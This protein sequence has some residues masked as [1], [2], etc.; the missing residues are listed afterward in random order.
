MKETG[1]KNIEIAATT[2]YP[3]VSAYEYEF[4]KGEEELQR[5][6]A[7]CTIYFILQRPLMYFNNVIQDGHTLRFD[8]VDK[9]P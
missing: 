1:I 6:M 8:I 5:R 7:G 2:R 9:V 3:I 4:L